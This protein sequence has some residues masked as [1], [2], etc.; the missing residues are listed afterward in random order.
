MCQPAPAPAPA[1]A[2]AAAPMPANTGLNSNAPKASGGE[3]ARAKR[4]AAPKREGGIWKSVTV[5]QEHDTTPQVQV[6]CNYGGKK[7]CGGA[8]RIG[9]HICGSG[10]VVACTCETEVST[11]ETEASIA[12]FV[13]CVWVH[14][15]AGFV[16]VF[17]LERVGAAFLIRVLYALLRPQSEYVEYVLHMCEG[18]N[19]WYAVRRVLGRMPLRAFDRRGASSFPL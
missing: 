6:Q 17:E 10:G 2:A 14:G 8:T 11:T 9:E 13:F 1:P 16:C 19:N 4:K 15:S 5:L 12:S 3:R 18:H 7:F